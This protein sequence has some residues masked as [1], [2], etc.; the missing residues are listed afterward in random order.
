MARSATVG[1]TASTLTVFM[2]MTGLSSLALSG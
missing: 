2:H 1:Y